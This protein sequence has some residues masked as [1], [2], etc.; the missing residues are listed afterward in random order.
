ME[1]GSAKRGFIAACSHIHS[2]KGNQGAITRRSQQ[3]SPSGLVRRR[4][5]E[6]DL[7]LLLVPD[8]GQQGQVRVSGGR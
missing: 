4:P 5:P 3:R 6:R 8:G 2:K 7:D 1:M